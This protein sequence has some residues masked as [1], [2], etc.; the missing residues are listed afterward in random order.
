MQGESSAARKAREA[1]E[2]AAR[3]RAQAERADRESA[4]WALGEEG[5]RRVSECLDS[6]AP[7]WVLALHD[8]SM[9]M[10]D[11]NI[12]H[13]AVTPAGVFVVDAKNWSGS[14]KVSEQVLRQNGHRRD[15]EVEAVERQADV[16][17]GLLADAGVNTVPVHGVLCLA[18]EA[19]VGT[20]TRLARIEVVD[21]CDLPHQLT[22]GSQILTWEWISYVTRELAKRLPPRTGFTA[23]ESALLPQAPP[24]E[25]V[26]F[27]TPWKKRGW[28]YVKDEV[29]EQGGY[30]DLAAGEVVDESGNAE[31]ILRWLLPHYMAMVPVGSVS[32]GTRASIDRFLHHYGEPASPH[33]GDLV[34]G[35]DWRGPGKWRLYVHHLSRTGAASEI[36][37]FDLKDRRVQAAAADEA[38]VRYCGEQYLATHPSTSE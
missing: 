14:A 5:E 29:G 27:L 30:L 8:R 4:T 23:A 13:V 37:W 17:R 9:P 33:F 35:I 12:D 3:L 28:I 18:G 31:V 10:G 20:P 1:S 32:E 16:V 6:L 2:R 7:W 11:G 19:L 25:H 38:V 15:P 22:S 21:L 34:I 24:A 36:G 26:L